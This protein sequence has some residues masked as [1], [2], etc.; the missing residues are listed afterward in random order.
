MWGDLQLW[1]S[2]F[3]QLWTVQVYS[4]FTK[5]SGEMMKLG[6][7]IQVISLRS[8]SGSLGN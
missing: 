1:F 5:S 3:V 8:V 2:S 6:K 4:N 7:M